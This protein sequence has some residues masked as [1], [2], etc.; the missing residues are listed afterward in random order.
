MTENPPTEGPSFTSPGEP[1]LSGGRNRSGPPSGR[2]RKGLLAGAVLALFLGLVALSMAQVRPY[3]FLP[4]CEELLPTA[5]VDTIPG[6]DRPRAEGNNLSI[7][8][9]EPVSAEKETRHIGRLVG[10][11]MILDCAVQDTDNPSL[12]NVE[13]MLGDTDDG[14]ADIGSKSADLQDGVADLEAGRW[15]RGGD[16]DVDVLAWRELS[17]A[18]GG[19]AAVYS[20]DE[21]SRRAEAAFVSTNVFVWIGYPLAEGTSGEEGLEFVSGFAGEV[22]RQ[23]AEEGR[24][25]PDPVLRAPR[26]FG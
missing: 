3:A 12:M 4:Y 9:D 1:P 22:N 6:T 20:T 16:A 13:A 25:S 11:T 26:P 21:D 18:D 17:T 2:L 19:Y 5:L 14:M 24:L 15:P 8:G 7:E 10:F 23:L